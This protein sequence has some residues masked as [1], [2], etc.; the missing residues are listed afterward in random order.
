MIRH[1]TPADAGLLHTLERAAFGSSAW[2]EN[3]ILGTLEHSG[4]FGLIVSDAEGAAAHLLGRAAAGEAELL[5]IGVKPDRR[6]RGLGGELLEAFHGEC[7]CRNAPRRFLEVRA[8]NTAAQGLYRA[9]SWSEA[10]RRPRY[11]R[12]GT[13]ALIFTSRG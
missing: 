2:S 3:Q 13:D 6:R 11:Y 4:G 10:G 1:A 7:E 12:D 5:R 9:K 8:D